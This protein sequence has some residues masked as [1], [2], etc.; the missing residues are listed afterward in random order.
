MLAEAQAQPNVPSLKTA[1]VF[2]MDGNV[3]EFP[4]IRSLMTWPKYDALVMVEK[5]PSAGVDDATD[6]GVSGLYGKTY[7]RVGL[8]RTLV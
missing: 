5:I 3:A 6:H 1:D 2:S 7:G 8:Y 4:W